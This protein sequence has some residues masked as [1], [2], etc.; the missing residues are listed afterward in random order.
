MVH[1][2]KPAKPYPKIPPGE[3]IKILTEKQRLQGMMK[4][5]L[6]PDQTKEIIKKL[7]TLEF[8][9]VG[10]AFT[11]KEMI[12]YLNENTCN[13]HLFDSIYCCVHCGIEKPKAE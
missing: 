1:E 8:T 11:P 12:D 2:R 6:M 13:D 9:G 3:V 10:L 5:K 4:N 7:S